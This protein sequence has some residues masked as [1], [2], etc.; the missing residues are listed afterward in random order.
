MARAANTCQRWPSNTISPISQSCTNDS[1][2]SQGKC[3]EGKREVVL[4]LVLVIVAVL[5]VVVE[6]VAAIYMYRAE[7]E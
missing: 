7:K 5:V 1:Y 6:A 4:V 2:Y 3:K